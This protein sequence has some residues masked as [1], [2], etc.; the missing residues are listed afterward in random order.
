LIAVGDVQ[1]VA[2]ACAGQGPYHA[3]MLDL[4][5]RFLSALTGL[6]FV[7]DALRLLS[8]KPD[9]GSVGAPKPKTDVSA[10]LVT[11]PGASTKESTTG[12]AKV[13]L[14]DSFWAYEPPKALQPV[15]R[16]GWLVVGAGVSVLMVF[17]IYLVI[18]SA[19]LD[20]DDPGAADVLF[21][22]SPMLAIVD[23]IVIGLLLTLVAARR[24][25][26]LTVTR[27]VRALVAGVILGPLLYLT[28]LILAA[29]WLDTAHSGLIDAIFGALLPTICA[30]GATLL[31]AVIRRPGGSHGTDGKP[32]QG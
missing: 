29:S 19:D 32:S 4:L 24:L 9:R 23:A 5:D 17:A 8:G 7:R 22:V 2:G 16:I 13:D 28:L 25:I 12:F 20:P 30:L 14:P 27:A 15:R 10:A 31:A 1:G 21:F 3:A 26:P 11:G 6:D 18:I